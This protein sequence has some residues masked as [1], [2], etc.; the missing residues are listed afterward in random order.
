MARTSSKTF[1]QNPNR[2]T[3]TYI[4]TDEHAVARLVTRRHKVHPKMSP[5]IFTYGTPNCSM[6]TLTEQTHNKATK[7]NTQILYFIYFTFFA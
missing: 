7:P 3:I 1:H 6:S 2:V 5:Q 4:Q